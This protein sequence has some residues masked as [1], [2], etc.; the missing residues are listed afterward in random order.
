MPHDRRHERRAFTLAAVLTSLAV[1]AA[2]GTTQNPYAS[3]DA[4]AIT[5]SGIVAPPGAGDSGP[6]IGLG[7]VDG[8]VD[9]GIDSAL[10]SGTDSGPP[11]G[12]AAG[13]NGGQVCVN[14]ACACPIYQ[15]FCGGQCIPTS[16]D[17]N[18]CGSCGNVCT[19]GS[20]C[21]GG[22]CGS[23]CLPGLTACTG[24]CVD[25]GSSNANCGKCGNVC[26]AGQGCVTNQSGTG[27]CQTAVVGTPPSAG[28]AGGGPPIVITEGD[29]GAACTG[30][31]AQT[32]FTWALCSCT[33]V[34]VSQSFLTDSYDSSKG[35]Y[36]APPY[37][38]GGSVGLNGMMTVSNGANIYGTFWASSSSGTVASTPMN[39]YQDLYSGGAIGTSTAISIA[40]DAYVNGDIGGKVSIGSTLYQP[41]ADTRA[42]GVTYGSLVNVPV[43]VPAP[44]CGPS[45]QV[46]VT[47]IV[48]GAA[49][50]NDDA[51]SG[52]TSTVLAKG[53]T[54][55]RLDL[56]CGNYYFTEINPQNSLTI[57]AHGH[58]AIYVQGDVSSSN[59]IEITLDPGMTL[60]VFIAGTI[61]T[62]QVITLGNPNYPALMRVYVGTTGSLVFSQKAN[63][64][65]DFYAMYAHPVSWSQAVT[66]YGSVYVGDFIAS[67]VTAIHY[68]RAAL[69]SGQS[70]PSPPIVADAGTDAGGSTCQSC[71]DCGNQ[72]CVGGA[73]GGCTDNSQCCAPLQCQNGTCV[74]SS[75]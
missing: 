40:D 51:T 66:V 36:Q 49:L 73:C 52:F 43:T 7:L 69:T 9:G 8:G 12:C 61:N 15:S 28:C 13:C 57:V 55:E 27:S 4:G 3:G 20:A 37:Q 42:A 31:I 6:P 33:D 38:L 18:N 65:A 24:A 41:T 72:A 59:P 64:A 16:S 53:S 75:K 17:G 63:I 50:T 58:T 1:A 46:P 54:V 32:L 14:G 25:L 47:S 62:S 67:Q 34:T 29:A 26:P 35:P 70:C 23:T 21:S 19:G 5:D 68:D 56:P 74:L 44:C 45:D 2:C 30:A 10:P 48:A 22:V 11:N 39:V 71:S 60:D